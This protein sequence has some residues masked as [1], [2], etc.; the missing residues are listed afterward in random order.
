MYLSG[1]Q[2][3]ATT[4]SS[5]GLWNAAQA[6]LTQAYAN[7]IYNRY[8]SG[9]KPIGWALG[10]WSRVSGPVFPPWSTDQF[11]RATALTVRTT[12]RT[13]RRRQVG[14]GR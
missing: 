2:T 6:A 9:T 12:M 10:V 11:A 5:G 13:Q 1:A 8:I 7:A 14:V 3:A 4:L